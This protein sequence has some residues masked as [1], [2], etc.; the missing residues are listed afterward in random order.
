MIRERILFCA[1][2]SRLFNCFEIVHIILERLW[3]GFDQGFDRKWT[4]YGLIIQEV[5]F[6]FLYGTW[7]SQISREREIILNFIRDG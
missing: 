7:S 5:G 2:N 6:L 1:V 4:S 3:L